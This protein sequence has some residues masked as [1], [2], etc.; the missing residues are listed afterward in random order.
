MTGMGMVWEKVQL[1]MKRTLK[2]IFKRILDRLAI[3]VILERRFSCGHKIKLRW[4]YNIVKPHTIFKIALELNQ[5][6]NLNATV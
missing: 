2:V 3:I 1:P 5:K 4:S 6:C